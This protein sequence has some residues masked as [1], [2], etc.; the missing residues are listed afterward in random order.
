MFVTDEN[1]N[2]I[3]DVTA[4]RAKSVTPGQGFGEKVAPTS[5]Q[6]DLLKQVSAN[7]EK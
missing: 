2:V 5:E 6:L 7:P 1:G 3:W 4:Q